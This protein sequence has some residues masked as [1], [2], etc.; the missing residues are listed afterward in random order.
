[1]GRYITFLGHDVQLRS[2]KA[3]MAELDKELC[4]NHELNAP[5]LSHI[6]AYLQ[7][8]VLACRG[9]TG[10]TEEPPAF[11]NKKFVAAGKKSELQWRFSKSTGTPGRKRK[12][13]TLQY[14]S[15]CYVLCICYCDIWT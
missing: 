1:M 7:N 3:L 15:S 2:A 6:N 14:V 11:S 9:A 8:A 13:N 5:Y 10:E 4:E 12:G